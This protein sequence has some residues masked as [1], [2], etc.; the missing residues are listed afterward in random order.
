MLARRVDLELEERTILT[1]HLREEI[2]VGREVEG[3][4][5]RESQSER[6]GAAQGIMNLTM[7]KYKI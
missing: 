3:Y 5:E 6:D 1:R 2:E 7:D 4:R